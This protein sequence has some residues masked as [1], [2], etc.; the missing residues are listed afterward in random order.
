MTIIGLPYDNEE[1]IFNLADWVTQFSKYQ[2][3]NL[4]TPL[5]ATSNWKDLQPLNERGELLQEGEMRPY[6]L[7]TGR[8]L[9]HYDERWSMRESQELFDRYSARLT[10]IDNLYGRLFRMLKSYRL[11]FAATS[12]ELGDTINARIGEASET[13]RT[14][15]DPVS[16]A[17]KEVG[18]S[19]SLR[20]N[21]LAETLRAVSQPLS[22]TRREIADNVTLRINELTESLRGLSDPLASGRKE[23]AANVS[24][25]I[26]ELTETLNRIT[27]ESRQR[28]PAK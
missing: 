7:Y 1:S 25:R 28:T 8:Q 19:L 22:N 27:L 14:W 11:R 23:L 4:L 9:V 15:S 17:G 20:V 5:P 10:S 6:H 24:K 18:D 3:A 16:V 21:E 26:G 2:T 12:R 13:L